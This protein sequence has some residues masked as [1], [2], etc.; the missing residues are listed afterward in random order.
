L[1][2]VAFHAFFYCDIAFKIMILGRQQG[3]D[4]PFF[5]RPFPTDNAPKIFILKAILLDI[6]SM[7]TVADII[8]IM[9]KLAHPSLAESWDSVGLQ[10][11]SRD[12]PVETVWVA[13]DPLPEVVK[14]ACQQQVDMLITH[15]PLLFRPLSAIDFNTPVGAILQLATQSG[16]TIFAAHTNLD[17]A[18]MGTN[19]CLAD[20]IGLTDRS[21]LTDPSMAEFRKLVIYAP[22]SHEQQV[23]NALFETRAGIIGEYTCCSFRNPGVGTF[24][25]S[26]HARPFI[27]EQG[28]ISHVDEVRIETRIHACH[29]AD[30]LAHVRKNHPYENMAYDVYALPSEPDGQGMGRVGNLKSP[31]SLKELTGSLK[32]ILN[33]Q[34]IRFAG[35]PDRIIRT[36]AVCTG[37]GS[38]LMK[39]FIASGADVYISGDLHYH[40][41]RT[42]EEMGKGLI[43]I[44]HFASEHLIVTVL[45][46]HIR[47]SLD[48]SGI[49]A[50]VEACQFETDPFVWM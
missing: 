4:R 50:R 2:P 3:G 48:Q 6:G 36:A 28:H 20:R 24:L 27:G 33:V 41:A 49:R 5:S 15:H 29:L 7:A 11:G 31:V 42:V 38:S 13:L 47:A 34:S 10:V 8:R 44:G 22:A 35:D 23:L 12:W 30:V 17:K 37:S 14:K 1:E 40:D 18:H 26:E 45:A 9:E 32:K 46:D 25:P 21:V 16:L 39:A 43:D 19:H